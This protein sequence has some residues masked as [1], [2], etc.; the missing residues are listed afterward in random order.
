MR[1]GCRGE[2]DLL[3]GHRELVVV[4]GDIRGGP[5]C[6]IVSGLLV[7]GHHGNQ[8]G[9]G[10]GLA[11]VIARVEFHVIQLVVDRITFEGPL[12]DERDIAGDSI[13]VVDFVCGL[14][15][16]DLPYGEIVSCLGESAGGH[17]DPLFRL[18]AQC[19]HGPG[20]TVAAGEPD[21]VIL[22]RGPLCFKL[23]I[24]VDVPYSGHRD[25]VV[26]VFPASETVVLGVAVRGGG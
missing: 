5:F 21:L 23:Y 22:D 24:L 1:T 18:L 25:D 9:V 2:G 7:D 8:V 13:G 26:A 19:I 16:G 14:A 4:D 17:G 11:R 10:S 6:H 15:V 12:G 3:R 20:G